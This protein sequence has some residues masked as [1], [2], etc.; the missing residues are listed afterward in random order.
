MSCPGYSGALGLLFDWQTLVAGLLA[1]GAGLLAYWSGNNQARA[2]SKAAQQ[3]VQALLQQN[4]Y[5]RL[6]ER[7]HLARSVLTS[8]RIVD[9]LLQLFDEN[10]QTSSHFDQN[11]SDQLT[12]SV[13]GQV[14]AHINPLPRY[15]IIDQLGFLGREIIDQYFSVSD[16]IAYF[17]DDKSPATKMELSAQFLM[18]RQLIK[19]LRDDIGDESRKSMSVLNADG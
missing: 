15:E 18:F 12:A 10:L 4:E 8:A 2:T 1:F 17:R 19:Q 9:G 13:A 14:R 16:K 5:M 11:G 3:E 6:S 7:R